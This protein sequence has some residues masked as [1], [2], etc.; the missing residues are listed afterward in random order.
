[1]VIVEIN[2]IPLGTKT[3]SVSKYI[4]NAL[5][6]IEREKDIKYELTPMGTIIEGELDKILDLA[7]R[8]HKATFSDKVKRVVTTIK[9]DERRNKSSSMI[10]KVKSVKEKLEAGDG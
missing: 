1:M 10:K 3:P 6:V 7:K 2:I 8:I 5:K 9:I 4:A